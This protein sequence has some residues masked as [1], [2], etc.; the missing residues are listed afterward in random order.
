MPCGL[1]FQESRAGPIG[2]LGVYIGSI[3]FLVDSA[4]AGFIWFGALSVR[5]LEVETI[6]R[7]PRTKGTFLGIPIIVDCSILGSIL[8][9]P[10]FRKL[11][12]S[13][14]TLTY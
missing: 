3:G 7:F 1:G 8:G 9:Y 12:Y 11:P 13:G 6:W 4:F 14:M 2:F 10:N 5:G